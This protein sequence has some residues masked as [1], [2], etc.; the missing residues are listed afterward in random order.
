MYPSTNY[1]FSISFADG[2]PWPVLRV[3]GLERLVEQLDHPPSSDYRD[4]PLGGRI[5][6]NDITIRYL[7]LWEQAQGPLWA[8]EGA[9]LPYPNF[10]FSV[11]IAGFP[12]L[13]VRSVRGISVENEV[14]EWRPSSSISTVKLADRQRFGRV[15]LAQVTQA[16]SGMGTGLQSMTTPVTR[17]GTMTALPLGSQHRQLYQ[18]L[19]EGGEWLGEGP[20][21]PV[22]TAPTLENRRDITIYLRNRDGGSVAQWKL[23]RAFPVTYE[24][25]NLDSLGREVLLRSLTLQPLSIDILS[26]TT[27]SNDPLFAWLNSAFAIPKRGTLIIRVYSRHAIAARGN[28]LYWGPPVQRFKLINAWVTRLE[29]GSLDAAQDTIFVKS[30]RIT[31][32]GIVE[33]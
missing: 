10:L 4:I 11:L 9:G 31:C 6:T 8:R 12:L 17:T 18:W 1:A 25:S 23:R 3:T 13:H 20:A 33:F 27:T 32:E 30:A 7:P 22:T 19:Q 28:P 15:T 24:L 5:G 29:F 26:E 21:M 16:D 14:L 2:A